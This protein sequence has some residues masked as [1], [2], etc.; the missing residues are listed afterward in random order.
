MQWFICLSY[1]KSNGGH[2]H[3]CRSE[4]PD[5]P[6]R[7]LQDRKRVA[8]RSEYRHDPAFDQ[9]RAREAAQHLQRSA[10]R[11]DLARH[12]AD[13]ARHSGD[14]A[15][16]GGDRLAALGVGAAG[17]VRPAEIDPRVSHRDGGHHLMTYLEAEAP[18]VAIDILHISQETPRALE[19]GDADLAIGFMPQLMAGFYQQTLFEQRFVC[20]ARKDHPRVRSKLTP[21]I[22]RG[23]T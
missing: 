3:G 1:R 9:H 16:S 6:R 7:G 22:P 15:G 5:D 11:P 21:A 13:A 4:A 10:F 17:R 18:S 8:C 19:S 14:E 23:S 12:G 20:L 2:R